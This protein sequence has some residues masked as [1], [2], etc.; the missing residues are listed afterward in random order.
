MILTCPDCATSYF[1]EDGRI[2]PRGRMV[3]CSS[4]GTRWRAM[5][6]A[7][8]ETPPAEIDDIDGEITAEADN[9]TGAEASDA[10]EGDLSFEEPAA[11]PPKAR[12]PPAPPPKRRTGLWVGAGIA[13]AM[14]ALV[15]TLAV[16]REEVARFAPWSAP[17]FAAVGLP[18]NELG[19]VIEGVAS[20]ATFEAG[21][22]VLSITGAIR[23]VRDA[24][25]EAPPI[26]ISLVD[27]E[28]KPL[29]TKLVEPIDPK[30]VPA[31]E[32]RF[33]RVGVADP[34]AGM[35]DLVIRFDPAAAAP[36][37]DHAPEPAHA[38]HAPEPAHAEP[39]DA[40]THH[41]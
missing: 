23:N 10:T 28:G 19:L 39:K 35:R 33:F 22:P 18:V 6:E 2:P 8:D 11:P 27:H 3:K 32:R 12:K 29:L 31:G 26:R 24:A 30:V 5:P 36:A 13:A 41:E 14:I 16:L 1:V 7:D 25:A 4:C 38:G 34:P 20:S 15:G 40:P 9:A 21:R 37:A 17:A